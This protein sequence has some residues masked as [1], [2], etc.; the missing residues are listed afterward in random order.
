[1]MTHH[2][3]RV[4]VSCEIVSFYQKSHSS[5]A[6]YLTLYASENARAIAW[7]ILKDCSSVD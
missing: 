7:G 1:M 6:P 5:D 2:L 4:Y 3:F